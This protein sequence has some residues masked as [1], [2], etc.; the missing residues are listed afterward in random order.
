VGS[1]SLETVR[2]VGG[3]GRVV[4]L[5]VKSPH[6]SDL[7]LLH[8]LKFAVARRANCQSKWNVTGC[9]WMARRAR[10]RRAGG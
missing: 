9:C 1:H 8:R 5:G 3:V 7:P 10:A 2:V 6:G 4:R